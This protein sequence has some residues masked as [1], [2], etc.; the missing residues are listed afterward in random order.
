[1]PTFAEACLALGLIENDE[2]WRRSMTEAVLWMMPHQ[3][4]CLFARI[5]IHCQPINPQSLWDEFKSAMSED[6]LRKYSILQSEKIAYDQVQAMLKDHNCKIFHISEM[7]A[8]EPVVCMNINEISPEQNLQKGLSQYN[9]LNNTQKQC[10][11][12]ILNAVDNLNFKGNRCFYID[13]PGGSGKTYLYKTL[14]YLVKGRSKV[15]NTMA[16][17]GIA[18]TLLP[19]GKTVHKTFGL[20]VPLFSDSCSNITAQSEEGKILKNVDLFIWDEAPMA[21]RYALEIMD[22]T[23]RYLMQSDLPFG[24]KIV[25]LGGDFRQLLP[26][27]ETATRTESVNLSIKFSYVWKYFK[28]FTLTQNM[29]VL[30]GEQEFAKFVLDVGNGKLNKDD[31]CIQVPNQLIAEPKSNI[32][33]DIYGDLIRNKKF[34]EAANCAILSARNVDV[35]EINLKVVDLL[36]KSSE[37]IFMSIDSVDISDDN[38]ALAGTIL[39]EDLNY[40]SPPTLPPHELR[41]RKNCVVMLIRNLNINEGLCNGT[42]LLV[43]DFSDH[44][45]KCEILTGD[46]VGEITF[47]NRITLHC[48]NTYT[49][50]FKRRQFPVKLAFAMTI[51]KSQGQTFQKIGIDLRRDVFNHGQFYVA[52]SRVKSWDSLK[53]YF[54]IERNIT[55][56]YVYSELYV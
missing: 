54:E 10:I 26:I 14:Y 23:L 39:T 7:D 42:R 56:N 25:V 21:P 51:N 43:L 19:E 13:G 49:F 35:Q 2:E 29:R 28:K 53:I 55:K 31:N 32:V 4:R 47:I 17:T 44:L 37:R 11:D 16:F 38:G 12:T 41:L 45:L 52:I 3:L 18:A 33:A 50:N 22:R 9:S 24:G 5:L 1:M 20:S 8:L 6:Y 36:D 15:V 48:D 27:K 30:P 40:L 46:K 34:K